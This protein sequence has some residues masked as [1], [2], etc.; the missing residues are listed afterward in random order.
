M[1]QKLKSFFKNLYHQLVEINDTPHRKAGGL[2]VGVFTGLLPAMGPVAAL[3]I[4]TILRVNRA[5]AIVGSLLTNTWISLLTFVLAIKLGSFLT[6]GNWR[7]HYGKVKELFKHFDWRNIFDP[8]ILDILKPMVLGYLII[9]AVFAA[10]VYVIA[11][12]VL[13]SRDQKRKEH[14]G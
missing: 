4:S 5:A 9:G 13:K 8:D 6:G 14:H 3:V 10:F 11:Y 7:E 12:F 2:A 1:N